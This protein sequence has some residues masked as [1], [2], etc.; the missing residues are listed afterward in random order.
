M[1]FKRLS[2]FLTFIGISVNQ[3]QADV[4]SNTGNLH[5]DSNY[6]YE[7]EMVLNTNGLGIGT[8]PSSNL[9][10]SGNAI[11]DSGQLIIGGSSSIGGST[12]EVQ[13]TYGFNIETISTNVSVGNVILSGNSYIFADTSAANGNIRLI[14]PNVSKILGRQYTIKK[15]DSS[16][17]VE[18]IGPIDGNDKKNMTA[19][20]NT[21]P[22]I[23]LIS[24][25]VSWYV[26]NISSEGVSSEIIASDNLIAWWKLDETSGTTIGDSSQNSYQGNLIGGFTF[27]DNRIS[28]RVGGSLNFDGTNDYVTMGDVL[29]MGFHSWTIS[30]WIN[31]NITDTSFYSIIAKSRVFTD[32]RYFMGVSNKH[33]LVSFDADNATPSVSSEGTT[34]IS[35]GWFHAVGTYD[36]NGNLVA[37]VNSVA[38]AT[39]DMS[40][41]NSYDVNSTYDLSIGSYL[42]AGSSPNFFFPG[43]IDDVRI[44]N[45]VLTSEEIK[46]LYLLGKP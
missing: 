41:Y 1:N 24:N 19:S 9:H 37:Y 11:L 30:A 22:Y 10:V 39:Q 3:I 38:E 27:S 14:L 45:R 8:T 28:G 16:H 46:I 21:L 12:L 17:D 31:A 18:I 26:T 7:Y 42:D 13:G 25:G 40:S 20:S 36:R 44:Y 23:N 43:T 35:S 32:D 5:F 15:I 4:V 34:D 29:D 33:L 2:Y 6:D